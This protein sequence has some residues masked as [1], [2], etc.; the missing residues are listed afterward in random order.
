[1]IPKKRSS[2]FWIG[3]VILALSLGILFFM[4]PLS[5]W[6][7]LW[8]MALWMGLAGVGFYLVTQ[9]KGPVSN[10]VD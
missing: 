6:I 2:K 3:N 7:G 1:M 9:D 4:G 10:E 8:A 5:A